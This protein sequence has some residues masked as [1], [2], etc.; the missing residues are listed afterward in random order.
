MYIAYKSIE[1]IVSLCITWWV[2]RPLETIKKSYIPGVRRV[3]PRSSRFLHIG[4]HGQDPT[5]SKADLYGALR[6]RQSS[7]VFR[8]F[9]NTNT[10]TWPSRVL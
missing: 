8:S 5:F 7:R 1:Y 4:E 9:E 6:F 10:F 3:S 2:Q